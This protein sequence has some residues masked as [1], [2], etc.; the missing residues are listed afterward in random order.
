MSSLIGCL[1]L[2]GSPRRNVG[3]SGG[4]T[5][6][7]WP[8][9]TYI[10]ETVG[11]FSAANRHTTQSGGLSYGRGGSVEHIFNTSLDGNGNFYHDMLFL[12]V[13]LYL[14]EHGVYC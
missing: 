11:C 10:F 12:H 13:R 2:R 4:S 9:S 6:S 8:S 7:T 3:S 14:E 5:Y 1:G